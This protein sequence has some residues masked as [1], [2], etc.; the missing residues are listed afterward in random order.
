MGVQYKLWGQSARTYISKKLH[1]ENA[2]NLVD[3]DSLTCHHKSLP[4]QRRDTRLKMIFRWAPTNARQCLVGQMDTPL[5]PLCGVEQETTDHVM[6]CKSSL[7]SA[8]K[9]EALAEF[10]QALD[11]IGTHPDIATLLC[12]AVDT[13]PR[14]GSFSSRTTYQIDSTE[15]RKLRT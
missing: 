11:E 12:L 1:L 4:W 3:W 15:L 8:A 10:D 7:A 6:V 9:K 14:S 13:F 5:F 2:W